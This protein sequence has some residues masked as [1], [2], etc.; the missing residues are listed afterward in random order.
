[1]S[2]LK[3][4][5]L[6]TINTNDYLKNDL[7]DNFT[8]EENNYYN[9]KFFTNVV[10]LE[11]KEEQKLFEKLNNGDKSVVEKIVLHNLKYVYFIARN[12]TNDPFLLEELFQQG[13][14]GL[15]K[16][17]KTFDYKKGFRFSTYASY[18]IKK[19]IVE[20]FQNYKLIK[21]SRDD[22]KELNK[23]NKKIS[24]LENKYQRAISDQE[25]SKHTG[26]SLDKIR[27]IK[28]RDLTFIPLEQYGS[29]E[30]KLSV[31]DYYYDSRYKS[32]HIN[33]ANDIIKELKDERNQFILKKYLG[34]EDGVEHT[35]EQIGKMLG[36][37]KQ[38]VKKRYDKSL[39]EIRE[40]LK[41]DYDK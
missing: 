5:S 2:N 38:A 13:S 17:L 10:S 41:E 1:M 26:Y 14:Y 16:A 9:C 4:K 25:L 39:K 37:S 20:F 29:E 19:Y 3:T 36:I 15:M 33:I 6:N 35:F 12:Y 27:E 8:I 23:L 40:M 30:E 21:L 18:S 31:I 11:K 22:Y 24:K 32:I 34:I 28:K 7:D